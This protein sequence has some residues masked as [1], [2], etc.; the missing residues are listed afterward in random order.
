MIDFKFQI[1][2]SLAAIVA[3]EE[4]FKFE[5]GPF[6][7]PKGIKREANADADADQPAFSFGFSPNPAAPYGAAPAGAHG[8]TSIFGDPAPVHPVIHHPAAG[9]TQVVTQPEPYGPPPPVHPAPYSPTPA[10]YA[11]VPHH[12][13]HHG[14]HHG[15]AHHGAHHGPAHHG[16]HHGPP[17]HAPSPYAPAPYAQGPHHPGH[18][19]P[20]HHAP[21][22]HAAP[23]PVP[24][25]QP[26]PEHEYKEP[27]CAEGNTKTWCLEDEEYPKYEIQ[28]AI[29]YHYEAVRQIYKDVLTN[30]DNSVD[31]LKELV[32]ETYLCPSEAAYI[33]PLRAVSTEGKWRII[34]NGVTAHYE[35][36]TQ[37]V[38]VEE[39]TTAGSACPLIPECYETKCLQKS[40]Y[41]RFL[42]FN[43]YDH[44]LPFAIES[45]KLPSACACYNG[46]YT[47]PEL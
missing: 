37:T 3:S 34:V 10:P 4:N 21:P 14:A 38:R 35:D 45:F 23:Y 7:D 29:E 33:Q 20:V 40:I 11:P 46:A 43:P 31:R 16:A 28:K 15:P 6:D 18:H 5:G 41:H 36:L 39:C 9:V 13:V 47:D 32:E 1:L 2:F 26:Q 22:H 27:K 19:G 42:V 25:H 17:H 12:P 24:H 44:Y 30:T 8:V